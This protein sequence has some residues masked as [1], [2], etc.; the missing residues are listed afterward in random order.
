MKTPATPVS[1]VGS[2]VDDRF[3]AKVTKGDGCWLWTGYRD[4]QGYGHL[5]RDGTNHLAHRYA[6]ALVNG[7]PTGVIRHTCDTPAC[8]RPEHLLDGT[9]AQN[10]A[11][12]QARGRHRPGRMVGEDHPMHKLTVAQVTEA[13]QLR[14]S[15]VR[16][17]PIA[18]T[19]GVSYQWMQRILTG[20]TWK[21]VAEEAA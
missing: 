5:M 1:C 11:D 7:E 9:Q 13:R 17:G 15:G 3:W 10:I 6:F 4:R 2:C 21:H 16:I 18:A 19:Y 12:R 14:A 20:K 8:V